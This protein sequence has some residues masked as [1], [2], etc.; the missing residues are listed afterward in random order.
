MSEDMSDKM[1]E[2]LPDSTSEHT[3]DRMQNVRI[4]ARERE[5]VPE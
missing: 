3:P 1:P 4:V 2:T 5:R